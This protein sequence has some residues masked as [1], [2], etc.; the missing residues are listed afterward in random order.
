MALGIGAW[1][2][3]KLLLLRP[4]GSTSEL[5][6]TVA[7]KFSPEKV[8]EA[9]PG[10]FT[11]K[12]PDVIMPP[13]VLHASPAT[14]MTSTPRINAHWMLPRSATSVNPKLGVVVPIDRALSI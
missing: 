14:N 7:A 8:P 2:G 4:N 11:E 13:C 3:G 5:S 1:K 12:L 6:N 9:E 10:S